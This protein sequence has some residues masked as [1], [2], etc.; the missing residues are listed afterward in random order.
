MRNTIVILSAP[1]LVVACAL[2]KFSLKCMAETNNLRDDK[3]TMQYQNE[4][5]PAMHS[6]IRKASSFGAK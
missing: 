3:M 4:Y 5:L 2:P 6:Y 1:D